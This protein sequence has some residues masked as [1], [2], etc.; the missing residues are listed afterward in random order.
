[1]SPRVGHG[2]SGEPRAVRVVVF[3]KDVQSY[4][5]E[6]PYFYSGW[7]YSSCTPSKSLLSSINL[8]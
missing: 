5:E 2:M 4:V 3:Q 7:S 8:G 1:M 6:D